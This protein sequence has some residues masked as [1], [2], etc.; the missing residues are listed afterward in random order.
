M[1]HPL[2]RLAVVLFVSLSSSACYHYHIQGD[3]V[4][5]ATEPR[6]QTQVAYLWGLAQPTDITPPDC[7]RK[8]PLAEVTAHTNFGYILIGAATLGIV[9]IQQIEWRCAK[10]PSGNTD[11]LQAKGKGKG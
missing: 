4:T 5:P 6:S 1:R 10:L 3:R 9:S 2:A 7:P 8:V 11:I